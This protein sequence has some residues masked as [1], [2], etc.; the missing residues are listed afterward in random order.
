MPGE[1]SMTRRGGWPE[2][3]FGTRLRELREGAGLT[4][5]QLGER[6]G[7]HTMTIAKLEAA[8]QEPAWPLV[9]ALAGALGVPVGAFVCEGKNEP[10]PNRPRGRPPK[11]PAAPTVEAKPAAKGPKRK[12]S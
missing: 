7:C 5:Q 2:T 3:G 10:A 11:Q 12:P 4:Q 6:A 1:V 8:T 9:L